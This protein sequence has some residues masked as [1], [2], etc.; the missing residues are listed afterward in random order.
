MSFWDRF[1][2]EARRAKAARAKER[3]GDLA[4]AVE[5]WLQADQPDEAARVLLVRADAERVPEKRM[6]FCAQAAEVA[7]GEEP[8]KKALARKARLAFDILRGRGGTALASELTAVARD[9][10]EAGE[11]E[12]AADAHALAG[13]TEGEVRALTAAGAI[14]RLEE[15][16]RTSDAAARDRRDLDAVLRRIADLDRTA[17]R[18]AAL[19]LA[20]GWLGTRE[21]ERVA[22]AVRAVRARLLRGPLVDLRIEGVAGRWALGEVVTIGRGDATIVVGSRAISRRH[23]SVRR[24]GAEVVV[25]DLGTRNGTTLAGARL[26]GPLPIGAGVELLLGGEVACTIAPLE[27]AHA[28]FG[29]PLTVQ[30]AGER[31]LLPLGELRA[32][33]WRLTHEVRG[34]DAFVVLRT[35]SGGA[36]PFLDGFELAAEVELCV[37]DEIRISRNGAVRLSAHVA[38]AGTEASAFG[39]PSPAPAT[40]LAR[41]PS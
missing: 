22:D 16:L 10:E 26:S 20:A 9:L 32:G 14:E 35:A 12:T 41:G 8:R 40:R 17:E 30:V 13:D 7:R 5:L 3:S 34:D 25:E 38:G 36:R 1:G 39:T 24:L 21:D 28:V 37:G 18:R 19:E 27:D 33:D 23:V 11:L 6:A 4:T 2:R 31:Y 15:R 29:Q